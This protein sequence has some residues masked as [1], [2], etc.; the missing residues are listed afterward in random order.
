MTFYARLVEGPPGALS[1]ETSTED[2]NECGF[3]K[4]VPN[5]GGKL[6]RGGRL[7]ML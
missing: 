1:N 6:I 4:F 5:K 7:D 3:Y 2:A